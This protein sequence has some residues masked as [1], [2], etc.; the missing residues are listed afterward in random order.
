M[1]NG[2]SRQS[3]GPL[4]ADM[5][6]ITSPT[7]V[8]EILKCPDI[9]ADLHN[10]DSFPLLGGSVL[11]LTRA[12][13][14]ERRRIEARLFVH[15]AL[16][17][18]EDAVLIPA[19]RRRIDQ[20]SAASRDADGLVRDDLL[21]LTRTV[22][23]Q[24]TAR[25]IGLDGLETDSELEALYGC[26]E[27][28][29][30]A[31]SVEWAVTNHDEIVRRGLEAS[32]EFVGAWFRPSLARRQALIA[33]WGAGALDAKDLPA[34][35]IGLLLVHAPHLRFDEI[36]REAIFFLLASSS[37]TTH[38]APH[39]FWELLRWIEQ[40]PEDEQLLGDVSFI[41]RVV[42][43]GLRLHPP[44]PALLRR[45][46]CDVQ[47]S[48]GRI[49]QRGECLALDLDSAN[50]D[51]A[52][53][54]ADANMFNPRRAVSAGPHPYAFSF[55]GGPHTCLGRPLATSSARKNPS[56]GAP[57]ALVRLIIELMAAGMRLDP[58]ADPP[59]PRDDTK[60]RRFANFPVVFTRL[61]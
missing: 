5:T 47:L 48:S 12:T 37:T 41:K 27:K 4:V 58:I 23:V 59:Q 57:G 31:A 28:F 2:M 38:A 19:I 60:A 6:W 26:A 54:G 43:E 52:L 1:G 8:D 39:V 35:L 15:A 36:R 21:V 20:L 61:K 33:Q 32:D 24:M 46:L 56:D 9:A 50:Q 40:H 13:H 51:V 25:M 30:E 29:G 55:G 11:T 42:N 16:R 18:Y 53:F 45:A 49:I 34:D 44:V 17:D 3:N 22:L 7:E 14:L 10:R